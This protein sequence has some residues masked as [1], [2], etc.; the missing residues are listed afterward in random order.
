[1]VGGDEDGLSH[2]WSGA[3]QLQLLLDLRWCF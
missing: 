1:V 3:Y 2:F